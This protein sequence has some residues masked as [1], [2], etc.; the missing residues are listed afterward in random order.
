[1]NNTDI[2][3][4]ALSDLM[5]VSNST[6]CLFCILLDS[7]MSRL[8]FEIEEQEE[9]REYYKNRLNQLRANPDIPRETIY[10]VTTRINNHRQEIRRLNNNLENL[11][12][13]MD[14]HHTRCHNG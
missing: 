9:L 8:K 7:Q 6:K 13:M 2:D 1:M 4:F 3:H 10:V 14:R 11:E 12:D 5:D